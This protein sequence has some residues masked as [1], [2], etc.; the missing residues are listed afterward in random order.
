VTDL[1]RYPSRI[2]WSEEDEGFIAEAADLP[3]CSAFGETAEEA[4]REL[5]DAKAAWIEAARAA[6]NPI[7]APSTQIQASGKV[8]LRMPKNLHAHLAHSAAREHVS[9]NQYIVSV[10]SWNEGLAVADR[11]LTISAIRNAGHHVVLGT[12]TGTWWQSATIGGGWLCKT[13]RMTGDVTVI[14][15]ALEAPAEQLSTFAL[16]GAFSKRAIGEFAQ[17]KD[18][19]KTRAG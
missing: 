14:S 8:L 16:E 5:E 3:G 9:L 10:L 18:R 11:S 1:S 2:F 19:L 12:G 4:I 13:F 7:P 17:G 15:D 6:G